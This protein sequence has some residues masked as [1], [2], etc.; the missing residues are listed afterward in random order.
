VGGPFGHDQVS[1]Y[2]LL[3]GDVRP[4]VVLIACCAR[5][6]GDIAAIE[7]KFARLRGNSTVVSMSHITRH[8]PGGGR[9]HQVVK[10]EIAGR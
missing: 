6:F 2:L 10:P 8:W 5:R 1:G 9:R 3:F 7:T 4:V